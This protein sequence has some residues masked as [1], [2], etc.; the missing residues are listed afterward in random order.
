MPDH[1][2]LTAPRVEL[3]P[4]RPVA[5]MDPYKPCWCGSGTKYKWCHHRREQAPKINPF[6]IEQRITQASREGG[7]SH[8]DPVADPCQGDVIRSHTVQRNGG[9]KQIAENGH[10][11]T[12]KPLMKGLMEMQ[13]EAWPRPVGTGKASVFPGFCERHDR[14]LFKPVEG[15]TLPLD[16]EHAF[17]LA[18]R[19]IAYERHAKDAQLR[20]TE[21]QRDMDGGR[22]LFNQ[23][24][25][26]RMLRDTLFGIRMGYA[27]I[28]RTKDEFDR[29]LMSG[30]RS[31]FHFLAVRFDGLLPMVAC[32]SFHAE[33]D[34]DGNR[35]QRLGH[36]D[37]PFELV[38][39]TVTAFQGRTVAVFGWIG[40]ADGPAARLVSSFAAIADDGKADALLRLLFVQTD[41]IFLRPS[42]WEGL[43]E[44]DQKRL[45][46]Q[47]MAGTTAVP[48]LDGALEAGA[49][50]LLSAAVI[51]TVEG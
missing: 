12:V 47:V 8:P 34:F 30:D 13:G 19:A 21:L 42:W 16:A 9:L 5:T 39:L 28:A 17:L 33:L 4:F 26:Q 43:D 37:A 49:G 44:A 35:L 32:T 40:D 51:E 20:A 50:P 18:Y 14:E 15:S 6:E 46:G 10:V 29:R 24:I 38:T 27:D 7:C 23:A 45:V 3:P 25:V 2:S 22:P 1:P 31:G 11:L 48:R 36:G 41:N